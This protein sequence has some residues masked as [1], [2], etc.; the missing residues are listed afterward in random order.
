M[1]KQYCTACHPD[2]GNTINPEK[3]LH[4]RNREENGIKTVEDIIKDMR[5]PGP[6]MTKF[7]EETIPDADAKAIAKY[8]LE[9]FN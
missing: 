5:N 8:V 2:G 7:D 3:T 4:R 1:F 9:T 6:R